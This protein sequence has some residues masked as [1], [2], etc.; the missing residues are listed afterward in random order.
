LVIRRDTSITDVEATAG[1]ILHWV[2]LTLKKT[3]KTTSF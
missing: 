3:W 2:Y 1:S